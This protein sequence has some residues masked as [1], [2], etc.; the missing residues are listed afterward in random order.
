MSKKHYR[1]LVTGACGV[2]SRS[3]VRALNLSE[4]FK[5]NCYFIGTDICDNLFGVYE[6]LY[7]K[8]YKVPA[9]NSPG[10]RDCICEII[11]KEQLQLAIVIPEPEVLYWSENPFNIKFLKIPPGFA[12]IGLSKKKLY[13]KLEGTGLIPE[14][15]MLSR[16]IIKSSSD[17]I[18]LEYPLWIRDIAEGTTSG[19]GSY[20]P[21]DYEKLKAWVEI[22]QN[23]E[24]FMI[25]EYL[26]GRN[27]AC[28]LLY[29][30]GVL[31]K[32]GV[33]ERLQYVMS[34]A[35]IS[36][37]TGNT[38]RGRLIN[39]G[40]VAETANYAVTTLVNLTNETMNGLVVVDLKDDA[41]GKP[42]VTEINIRHVAFTSSFAAAGF[43]LCEYQL[44]CT[45]GR[46]NEMSNVLEITYP[47]DNI[48]LRD[49][50]GEPIYLEEKA[51]TRHV[52]D[53]DPLCS[54][55]PNILD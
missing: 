18:S 55:F 25:S 46:S 10:Y 43:N 23:I 49:I 15:Q 22:N 4:K 13:E 17:A 14:Y 19:M 40:I 52:I 51:A 6:G 3:V 37:V 16:K 30:D 42:F 21:E 28:F 39:D 48:V 53:P 29:D 12:K 9:C 5:D 31:K 47:H 44:L 36:G 27:M 26:P 54:G 35:S 50:D 41:T 20:R 24:E 8:V 11:E 38:S 7:K 34:K 1:I 33:A 45:L 32:Q 2:T